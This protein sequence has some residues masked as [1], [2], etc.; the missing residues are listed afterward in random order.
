MIS[1]KNTPKQAE[2][3]TRS[4]KAAAGRKL[5][6]KEIFDQKASFVYGNL[7]W[8]RTLTREQVIARLREYEGDE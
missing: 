1:E 4:L 2:D 6:R 3:L 7:P 5:S 8:K